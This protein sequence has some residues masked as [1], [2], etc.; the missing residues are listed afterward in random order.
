MLSRNTGK[1]TAL[2]QKVL[3]DTLGTAL[4]NYFPLPGSVLKVHLSS[5]NTH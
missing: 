1:Q 3:G 5:F 2:P 4:P